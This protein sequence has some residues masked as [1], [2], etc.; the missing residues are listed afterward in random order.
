MNS[1]NADINSHL[2]NHHLSKENVCGMALTLARAGLLELTDDQIK[3]MTVCPVHRYTLGKYWQAPKTCQYPKHHGKKMAIAGTHVINFKT[4]RE[5][6]NIFGE[7]VPVGSR[8]YYQTS[9]YNC[10]ILSFHN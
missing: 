8:K 2:M 1:C 9:N 5:I 3:N 7:A 10:F 6:K 4:A